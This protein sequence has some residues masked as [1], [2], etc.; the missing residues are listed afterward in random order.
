MN[1]SRWVS[2]D[3]RASI[4]RASLSD[5]AWSTSQPHVLPRGNSCEEPGEVHDGPQCDE[6]C[7][8]LWPR[9]RCH[10]HDAGCAQRFGGCDGGLVAGGK[11]SQATMPPFESVTYAGP[12]S[13]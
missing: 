8:G 1:A 5:M 13:A 10:G 7:S 11:V 6:R 4:S 12:P 2:V 3:V 9:C